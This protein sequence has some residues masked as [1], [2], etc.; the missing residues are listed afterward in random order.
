[1]QVKNWQQF[2]H[3][4]DRNPTW[5]KLHKSLLDDFDF[6]CLPVASKALA[7]M[8]WLLASENLD[9]S[10]DG[11]PAKLAFRFRMDE[12]EVSKA[13]K[14]LIDKGFISDASNSLA[15]CYQDAIPET[16]TETEAEKRE[17]KKRNLTVS[18][19]VESGC[20]E[21]SATELLAIRKK[22]R[23][24]L[25]QL[26]WSGLLTE[27]K[28]AGLTPDEGIAV[29]AMRGWQGFNASWVAEKATPEQKRADVVPLETRA[30]ICAVCGGSASRKEGQHYFCSEHSKV[31]FIPKSV[32]A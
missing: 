8:I 29:M 22:K 11:N 16:E 6:Q 17:S 23:A 21:S 9:G 24:D 10:F 1:M 2:Q 15:D 27:F 18:D 19:L 26:A 20:S 7:M 12:K 31:S 30:W 5:I 25:T 4:K 28:K 32:M 14:P 3:Y 13:I